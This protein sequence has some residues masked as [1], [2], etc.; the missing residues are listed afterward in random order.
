LGTIDITVTAFA[1]LH[2]Q[3]TAARLL[4][5]VFALTSVV[6]ATLGAPRRHILARKR[7]AAL[8]G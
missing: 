6:I 4:L 8:H 7:L 3:P 1:K 5:A 2:G